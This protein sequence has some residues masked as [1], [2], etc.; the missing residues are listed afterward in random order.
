MYRGHLQAG[1]SLI[2][3][4]VVIVVLL[5]GI[6]TAFKVFPAG[7]IAI[8]QSVETT[9]A[10]QLAKAEMARIQENA[11]N[12]PDA[13]YAIKYALKN[14]K[15]VLVADNDL[16][17]D[18]LKVDPRFGN[19]PNY[20]GIDQLYV[21]DVN[22]IRRIVGERTAV[23]MPSTG[24]AAG[25]FYMMKFAPVVNPEASDVFVVYGNPLQPFETEIDRNSQP[26]DV[27]LPGRRLSYVYAVDFENG[28]IAVPAC[29]DDLP[30]NTI[31]YRV[32][33]TY[34]ANENGTLRQRTV[35]DTVIPVGKTGY[36]QP[37]YLLDPAVY[38][39][40]ADESKG[41]VPDSVQVSLAFKPLAETDTFNPDWP[42]EVKFDSVKPWRLF[43]NP[44]G[45]NYKVPYGRGR[46]VPLTVNVSYDVLDWHIMREDRR[47][48]D[49][50][51]VKLTL[52][53]LK[54]SGDINDDLTTYRG[55]ATYAP[56]DRDVLLI[57]IEDGEILSGGYTVD[58]KAGTV[59]FDVSN[60]D[61]LKLVGRTFRILYKAHDDWGLQVQKANVLYH[62]AWEYDA[63]NGVSVGF[64]YIGNTID[65]TG[66]PTRIYFPRCDEGKQITVREYFYRANNQTS[67]GFNET[68]FIR[69]P[70]AVDPI[71]LPYIDIKDFHP[72][73]ER[74]DWATGRAVRGVEGI[75]VKVRA[76]WK[77]SKREWNKQDLDGVVTRAEQLR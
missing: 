48:P 25:S 68:F 60:N 37:I 46:F 28:M 65:G 39:P 75:S 59:Q 1:A 71:P 15:V 30:Y 21:S 41:I 33:F 10:I 4:L 63:T 34:Y 73:A 62:V 5:V 54:K 18:D 50:G 45:Y 66:D 67:R 77:P 23:P 19:D 51:F 3:V 11:A 29:P 38:A 57:D 52:A 13:I 49:N 12:L 8:R 70:D 9:R 7:F 43:F 20:A 17:P 24:S 42:Y 76:V 72:N 32:A 56:F 64:F 26:G 6:L 58:Y 36:A 27:F 61:P 40:D 35:V 2:E 22:R 55:L 16:R 14:G 69:P 53:D 47:V 74:F 44:A 31:E